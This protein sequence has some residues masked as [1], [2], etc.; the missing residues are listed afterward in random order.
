MRGQ[1][2]VESPPTIIQNEHQSAL[3]EKG[4]ILASH[5]A[6]SYSRRPP[7]FYLSS[8]PQ[9]PWMA[10]DY[11]G[12]CRCNLWHRQNSG[13]LIEPK[14]END[15]SGIVSFSTFQIFLDLFLFST[16]SPN[17]NDGIASFGLAAEFA[18]PTDI[19]TWP[20]WKASCMALK[21]A[22]DRQ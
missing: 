5:V 1:A 8:W 6:A 13:R 7:P 18:P 2:T 4:Y 14:L 17:G 9:Q 16:S 12:E 21:V 22:T 3:I 11:W 10:D 15:R 20:W 19:D